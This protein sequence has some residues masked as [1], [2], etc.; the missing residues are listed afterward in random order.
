MGK[1]LLTVQIFWWWN[2]ERRRVQNDLNT[3]ITERNH[4][5]G[6]GAGRIGSGK[7]G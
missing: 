4:G 6:K 7:E 1:L 2:G 5:G 3:C